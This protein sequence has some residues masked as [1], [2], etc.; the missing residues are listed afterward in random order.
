MALKRKGPVAL[1]D[2]RKPLLRLLQ[3]GRCKA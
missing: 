1:T 2:I 3:D